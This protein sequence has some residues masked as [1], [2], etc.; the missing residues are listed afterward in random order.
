M[1]G[2]A[3]GPAYPPALFNLKTEKT[4]KMMKYVLSAFAMLALA[5]C[6]HDPDEITYSSSDPK[7]ASHYDVVVNENTVDETFTLVWSPARFGESAE[8]TYT[9]SAKNGSGSYVELGQ[10]AACNY[11]CTNAELF[12]AL[13]IRLT[14]DYPVT[15]KVDARSTLGERSS[16]PLAINFI[17]TKI[18]YLWM[19]GAYQGWDV[20]GGPV[21]RLLQDADG[22]FKGFLQLPT[23]GEFKLS[24]Q[25]NWDGHSYGPGEVQGTLAADIP[26]NFSAAAGLYYVEANLDEMTYVLLPLTS[27]SLIGEAV[28]GWNDG[29]DVQMTYNASAKCWTTI[30]DVVAGKDY[31]IRFNNM[32]DIDY[33]GGTYNCSLGGDPA[34]LKIASNDNLKAD[35]E[36]ITGFTL[37]LFDYPYTLSVGE[38][39]E[40]DTKLYVA[41]SATDWDYLSAPLLQAIYD[42]G[43]LTN[44]FWGL[45]PQPDGV[46]NPEILL[47]RIPSPLGTRYGGSASALV[48]YAAGVEAAPI[49]VAAGLNFLYADLNE[50]GMKMIDLPVTSVSGV[51]GFNNWNAADKTMAFSQKVAG[52]NGVWTATHTFAADG[53]FK[54]VFNDAFN[55]T[56]DGIVLQTSLGGSCKDLQVN[57]PNMVITAGE[58]T[59]ELD[60]ASVPMTLAI[61]GKIQDLELAPEYLEV[62]GA[63]AHYNWNLGD[64]SP[65][66][67][68]YHA[69]MDDQNKNRFA[70]FV[71]MYK[72]ADATGDAAEFKITYPVWSAWLGGTLQDGSHYIFNIDGKLNDNITIPYGLYYWD[73]TLT[74]PVQKAGVATA[75]AVTSP[76][77]I[78]SALPNGWDAQENMT[79]D[80]TDHLYKLTATLTDGELKVR[81]DDNWDINLGGDPAA[82]TPGGQ[83][84]A[85]TAGTYD[86]VLDLV[87]TPNTLT[88]TKK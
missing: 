22:V 28:G 51:G 43:V 32:W 46:A 12:S 70:G 69:G 29:D 11:S 68:V 35:T 62:T 63:F 17:Y 33:L 81:F 5:A 80:P 4:M 75:T 61:D 79:Y 18:T 31:K 24:S 44:T 87:H 60:L 50:G 73:I 45:L 7:I 13:G 26:D 58:H 71:D 10:T 9:V 16:A 36:G 39:P 19:F 65:K 49:P 47:S 74:D 21:S 34:A 38:M 1:T 8:V 76:G 48:K 55:T 52:Q 77:L 78:G 6:N 37:S 27:V 72:P 3:G 56:I 66:L 40:D 64:P 53:E 25:P 30:A 54:I 83:N 20:A 86:I 88:M 82:L 23:D 57:G 41:T 84:I 14:G 2:P 15:F 59:F 42:N 67:G 85:V